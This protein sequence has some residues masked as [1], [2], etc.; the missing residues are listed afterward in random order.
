M[1][2]F[3]GGA[4][5]IMLALTADPGVHPVSGARSANSPLPAA[6]QG[7]VFQVSPRGN[8]RWSGRLAAPNAKGTDGPFATLG[9]ARD[10]VRQAKSRHGAVTVYLHGGN[11]EISEPVVF[12]PEDSGSPGAPVTYAASPSDSGPPVLNGGRIITG[13]QAGQNGLWVA[14]I[15]DLK[16]GQWF[17]HQF[18]ANGQR[19]HRASS[20]VSG[21]ANMQGEISMDNQATFHMAGNDIGPDDVQDGVEA[22]A[23]DKWLD[24][25]A[26]VVSVN[27]QMV[28]LSRRPHVLM[29]QPDLRYRFENVR[30]GLSAEGSWFVSR[31]EGAIYYHPMTGEN[32][33]LVEAVASF[34][35]QMIRLEGSG[36]GSIHDIVFRGL[37]IS[38]S[39]W[40]APAPGSPNHQSDADLPAAVEIRGGHSIT[41]DHC[42]F[43]HIGFYALDFNHG[44]K[45][46]QIVNNEMSDLGAGGLK[47][48]EANGDVHPRGGNPTNR[49]ANRGGFGRW[50][51]FGQQRPAN[52]GPQVP[53]GSTNPADYK[54]GAEFPRSDA[55]TC[56]GNTISGNRIHD[57][58]MAFPGAGGIWIGQS[59]GNTISHNDVFNTYHAA[60]SVGWS[61]VLTASAAHDNIIEFNNVYNLGQ[62]LMSD[63]GGIYLLGAQPGTVVRNNVVHDVYAYAGQ[64][65]YGGWGIY[66][67]AMTNQ[68]LVRDNLVYRTKEGAIHLNFGQ[69]NTITNNI[70]A[71]G[72]RDQIRRSHGA[73][74]ISLI[75][76]HNIVYWNSGPM[77]MTFLDQG[78]YQFDYNLYY[79][80]C[81]HVEM[82]GP[83]GPRMSYRD[84][85]DKGQ[86]AHSVIA[87]PMFVDPE[88]GN[89][90]LRSGSPASQIGFKPFDYSSAG[91]GR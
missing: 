52:G 21:F 82:S 2:T 51:G 35:P 14:Q 32:P 19:R 5:L 90:T 10:A 74:E 75:V 3:L 47:I 64:Y 22:L 87:D 41:F 44:A 80:T 37:T 76:E 30:S 59:Y 50:S 72:D 57:I 6:A 38:Y 84:W 67:D 11:Y 86:D 31:R 25:R 9:R 56:S 24:F 66:L 40:T 23:L 78:T 15:P 18:F 43:S 68:V 39:D 45:S 12:R 69:N 62:G 1:R 49:R 88:H 63:I 91:A 27:G 16:Q 85:Q 60:I 36:P 33:N 58:G 61:W 73:P 53:V 89:F 77:F 4:I 42:T 7:A 81:G 54:Y 71:L 20:P 79:C 70:F 34:I 28:T 65:G 48:G 29:N 55:E 13:W 83:H 46:N 17:P 26:S 8:N